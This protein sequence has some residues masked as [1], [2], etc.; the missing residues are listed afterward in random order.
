MRDKILIAIIA[1]L[2]AVCVATSSF[3]WGPFGMTGVPTSAS[4]NTV[5]MSRGFEADSDPAGWAETDTT[6]SLNRYDTAQ[7]HSGTHSMSVTVAQDNVKAFQYYDMGGTSSPIS[8]SFWFYTGGLSQNTN[9]DIFFLSSSSACTSG[10]VRINLDR[11]SGVHRLKVRGT[12]SATGIVFSTGE[13][14]RLELSYTQ[15]ST[16]RLT[17]Y[18][19]SGVSQGY[20]EVT[21]NNTNSRYLCFGTLSNSAS[22]TTG[23]HYWDDIGSDWTDAT[24]PLWPFTVGN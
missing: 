11:S 6:S 19:A 1:A 20:D 12:A 24:S 3:A 22:G 16:T 18:N 2:I 5:D 23:S 9:T 7:A 15:N 10:G 8:V 13:W 14:Y 4:L 17:V 21:A